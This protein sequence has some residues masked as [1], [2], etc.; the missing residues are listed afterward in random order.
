MKLNDQ[1][2]TDNTCH[3]LV[4]AA[5]LGLLAED[6]KGEKAMAGIEDASH[7]DTRRTRLEPKQ[8]LFVGLTTETTN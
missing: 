6:P 3:V 7:D 8:L 5:D 4:V 1:K 2:L